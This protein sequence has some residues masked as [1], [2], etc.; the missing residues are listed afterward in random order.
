MKFVYVDEQE[1]ENEQG[2]YTSATALVFDSETM[3]E[4]REELVKGLLLVIFLKES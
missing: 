1:A 3:A 4:F 2:K